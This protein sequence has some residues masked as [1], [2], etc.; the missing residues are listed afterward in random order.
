MTRSA[1]QPAGPHIFLIA[2]RLGDDLQIGD[3]ADPQRENR[4]VAGNAHRPQRRLLAEARR[5][6][7]RAG[8]A[9]SGSG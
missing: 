6:C 8:G 5:R 7:A 2:Q 4:K 3:V 9:P 1:T